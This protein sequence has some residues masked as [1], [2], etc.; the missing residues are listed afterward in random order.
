MNEKKIGLIMYIIGFI[1]ALSGAFLMATKTYC[2]GVIIV[3]LGSIIH[4]FQ[5]PENQEKSLP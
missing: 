2:A 5:I 3:L 4:S 1:T